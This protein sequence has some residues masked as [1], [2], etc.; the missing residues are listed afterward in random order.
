M[1]PAREV[2]A[3]IQHSSVCLVGNTSEYVSQTR[4]TKIV[5]TIDKSWGNFGTDE[6]RSSETLFRKE[7]QS[8][9][10]ASLCMS[11]SAWLDREGLRDDE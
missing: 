3:V 10:S 11:K 1:V 9:V 8:S 2:L 5:E 7:F 6:Y 4:R